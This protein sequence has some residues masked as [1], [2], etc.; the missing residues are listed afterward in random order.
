[1]FSAATVSDALLL[2]GAV[3]QAIALGILVCRKLCRQFPRFV[4]YLSIHV[5]LT[6][7]LWWFRP[8]FLLPYSR[9]FYTFWI[10]QALDAA[11]R[12]GIV[13]E[14]FSGIFRPYPGLQQLGGIIFRWGVAVLVL[15]ASI[16]AGALPS[17]DTHTL[18]KFIFVLD[19]SASVIQCGL[20]FLLFLFASQLQLHLRPYALGIALGFGV[21]ACIDL[22]TAGL[23]TQF[24][25]AVDL[26]FDYLR[27]AS[28]VFAV[29]VWINALVRPEHRT[30]P[31]SSI[32][33][34]NLTEWNRALLQLLH[35][36]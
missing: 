30:E 33:D 34:N 28:Y 18:I 22:A 4:A 15:V 8:Y 7:L 25:P 26:A 27:R 12:F 35:N 36:Q 29:A 21:M 11:V 1:M 6:L 10:G 14:L 17:P 16:V 13:Q 9:Y 2:G 23:R 19:L 31:A 32:P 24:G 5:V 3:G 20:I